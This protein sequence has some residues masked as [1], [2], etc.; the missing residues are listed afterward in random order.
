[1]SREHEAGL[2]DLDQ[3]HGVGAKHRFL[4]GK[5]LLAEP[6]L[7]VKL[8]Q[9]L[10]ELRGIDR[11]KGRLYASEQLSGLYGGADGQDAARWS[12]EA[13]ADRAL[14]DTTSARVGDDAAVETHGRLRLGQ[15]DRRR[16]DLKQP[17]GRLRQEDRTVRP[18]LRRVA[19]TAAR[20]RRPMIVAGACEG[21]ARRKQNGCDDQGGECW[22]S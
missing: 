6:D 8:R 14:H 21:G 3:R 20:F 1:M 2:L 4:A 7:L 16:A 17:L 12:R 19:V 10:R 9:R 11:G 13:A 18:P 15:L 22:P 5:P